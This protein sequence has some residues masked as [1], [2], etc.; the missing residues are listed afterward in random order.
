MSSED[1]YDLL[2]IDLGTSNTTAWFVSK[3]THNLQQ[4]LF[5]NGDFRCPSAV[6]YAYNGSVRVG[7][8][9]VLRIGHEDGIV[10]SSK[11]LIGRQYSDEIV[12]R[13]L[14]RCGSKIVNQNGYPVFEVKPGHFVSPT[15]VATE[16][17]K[18]VMM[19]ASQVQGIPF[20]RCV[21]TV[22]V[23]FSNNQRIE[24]AKAAEKAGLEVI[25]LTEEPCAAAFAYAYSHDEHQNG[26]FVVYDLG[27][28]TFDV[29]VV[30]CSELEF[31]ILGVGGVM[32]CWV[33]MT[34]MQFY[35]KR[36]RMSL[37][38]KQVNQNCFHHQQ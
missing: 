10:T 33:V 22:P 15:Q 2:G 11:R 8:A 16:I 23:Y 17:I 6:Q 7:R 28:G 34:L 4:V 12:L 21:I 13:S 35:S 19:K 1:Y 26:D 20:K 9:A 14:D 29:S 30:R 3:Y 36:L 38:I 31:D 32:I 25:C 27:G 18:Y 24:T 37:L 5:E